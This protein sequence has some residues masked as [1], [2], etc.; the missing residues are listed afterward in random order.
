MSGLKCHMLLV[1]YLWNFVC[2]SCLWGG[3]CKYVLASCDLS[4]EYYTCCG[5]H[6]IF[7]I[8]NLRTFAIPMCCC[9]FTSAACFSCS[10]SLFIYIRCVGSFG[11][12]SIWDGSFKLHTYVVSFVSRPAATGRPHA[13]QEASHHPEAR[14]QRSVD[15]V[16]CTINL[17]LWLHTP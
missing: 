12:S 3:I 10:P 15:A 17:G 14:I 13:N 9:C 8:G 16:S 1:M 6:T 5:G 11:C 2:T 4:K 7:L